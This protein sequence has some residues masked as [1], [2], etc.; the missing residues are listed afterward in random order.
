VGRRAEEVGM[1]LLETAGEA[2]YVAAPP[3]ACKTS[4][5]PSPS[6]L[7]S[8]GRAR[9]L[10]ISPT[11]QDIDMTQPRVTIDDPLDDD[12]DLSEDVLESLEDVPDDDYGDETQD[13][14]ERAA[15]DGMEQDDLIDPRGEDER[16]DAVDD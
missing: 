14:E 5:F 11:G 3:C 7:N 1:A 15:V 10:F 16:G 12:L 9:K 2:R 8:I 6:H 13:D 4:G